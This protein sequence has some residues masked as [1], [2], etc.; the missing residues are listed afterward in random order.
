MSELHKS[1]VDEKT[2]QDDPKKGSQL[3]DVYALEIQMYTA[4]K[5]IKKQKELYHKAL[6]I[7]SAIPHPRIMGIIREC[8]GKMHMREK[9][10]EKAHT[11]FF[12]VL[13]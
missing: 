2:G 7:Q 11:D 5:N 6:G 13:F 12:E 4:T 10:W 1:C 8:G 9:E 3:V